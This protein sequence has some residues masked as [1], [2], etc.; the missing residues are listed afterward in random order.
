M[1]THKLFLGLAIH[2]HQPVGNFPSVFAA[3]YERAYLPLVAA[4]ERHPSIKLSMHYSGPLLDW[5]QQNQPQFLG[6]VAALARRG[7]VEIIGG[8]Y[9]EPVLSSIPQDDR[10]GQI[11]MMTAYCRREFGQSPRGFWLAERVWE[12]DLPS[13]LAGAGVEWLVVDDTHFKMVGLEDK[14]LFGYHLTEDQG[15]RVKVYASSKFMRYAVPFKLVEEVIEYLRSNLAA[16]RPRIVVM[17][18]D[19]EKFGIWPETYEHCWGEAQWMERFLTSLEENSSWLETITLGTYAREYPARGLVY[20]PCA[21]YD[22]MMEW[23]LP[24][25]MSL[26]LAETKQ[27]LEAEGKKDAASLM[28]GGFWRSFMVK[29]PEIN[30]MH[31]KMLRVHNKVYLAGKGNGEKPGL[32]HLWQAQCNCPYWHG[33]F[34]GIYLADIRAATYQHLIE[35]EKQAEQSL[36]HAGP[37]LTHEALDIDNDGADELIVEGSAFG[38]CLK[39]SRGGALVE[40]DL[41]QPGFNVLSSLSRRPEAY[42][43]QMVAAASQ[44]ADQSTRTIHS[45]IRLKDTQAVGPLHYD[46]Y[47]RF[48]LLDHFVR[49][50]TD[51]PQFI[52]SSYEDLGQFPDLPYQARVD[53]GRDE[54]AILL[55]AEGQVP[56]RPGQPLPV[57]ISKKLSLRAG[58]PEIKVEYRIKNKGASALSGAVVVEWNINL[59]GGGHNPAA[60]YDAPGMGEGERNLDSSGKIG[61]AGEL[62]VGN[63]YLGIRLRLS[64][65][66]EAEVWRYAVETVSNSENGI[67]GLYQASCILVRHPVDLGPQQETSFDLTWTQI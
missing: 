46:R 55:S 2:N 25:D 50:D 44:G 5:L 35:A 58:Q 32:D 17:G 66:P 1:D 59:L 38:L 18:D 26:Q 15:C 4:L 22:E 9:Y 37:W 62:I 13:S 54:L 39:P 47:P 61:P 65:R 12:P 20:L 49:R 6:R 19:G 52:S 10:V 8:G 3:A 30:W 24:A 45:E 23:A 27:R 34:G 48:S 53:A 11:E 63:S 29:Y 64:L 40:W 67:E 14:D 31:K 57:E 33:I 51:L 60:Y 28:R 21:S 56:G 36:R 7:Q 43:K 42:H 16:G 41:H